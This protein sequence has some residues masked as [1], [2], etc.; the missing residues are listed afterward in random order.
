MTIDS[1]Y[2]R[3][4]EKLRREYFVEVL[5]NG[6]KISKLD[7]EAK[8]LLTSIIK[9][10]P[11]YIDLPHCRAFPYDQLINRVVSNALNSGLAIHEILPLLPPK[12]LES[13]IKK[14]GSADSL[15]I[16][17]NDE[18]NPLEFRRAAVYNM[19]KTYYQDFRH[20]YKDMFGDIRFAI[21]AMQGADKHFRHV[22]ANL[23]FDTIKNNPE[24][25]ETIV[26]ALVNEAFEYKLH[27]AGDVLC[28]MLYDK[29]YL[30]ILTPYIG[31]KYWD[32]GI[33]EVFEIKTNYYDHYHDD[34]Y[35]SRKMVEKDMPEAV[36][37]PKN[38][39]ML[40]F[41]SNIGE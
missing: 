40:Y 1:L 37:A 35:I 38:E 36:L 26:L 25:A 4:G 6:Q 30:D 9:L 12:G 29:E 31:K 32:G 11:E 21:P 34:W 24:H 10:L 23:I 39:N 27:W 18:N 13:C 19:F 22:T 7:K 14:M 2:D 16:I 8:D 15:E 33:C 41:T 17:F 20:I 28:E 3:L 5:I